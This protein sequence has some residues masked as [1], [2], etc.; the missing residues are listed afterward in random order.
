[1]ATSVTELSS[2]GGFTLAFVHSPIGAIAVSL[3]DGGA[4]RAS[5]ECGS[6]DTVQGLGKC[7]C[8]RLK[9]T[10]VGCT[11]VAVITVC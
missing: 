2:E 9:N 4:D 3:I 6:V 11:L 1:M 7:L 10:V 8:K 5:F